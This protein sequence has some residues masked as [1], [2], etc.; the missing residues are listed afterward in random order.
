MVIAERNPEEN[1]AKELATGEISTNEI[2][3][4]TKMI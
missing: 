4:F 3:A 1:L 2:N